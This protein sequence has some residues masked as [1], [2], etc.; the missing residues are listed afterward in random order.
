MNMNRQGKLYS[1][2]HAPL[3]KTVP[4]RPRWERIRDKVSYEVNDND[5]TEILK[6]LTYMS[7]LTCLNMLIISC[8]W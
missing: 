3:V 6:Y 4:G 7:T 5:C 1:Q 2:G 8:L